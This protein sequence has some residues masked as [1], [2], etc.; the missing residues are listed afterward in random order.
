[1]GIIL[2]LLHSG[3]R[4]VFLTLQSPTVMDLEQ[5]LQ[6]CP[7]LPSYQPDKKNLGLHLTI[8]SNQVPLNGEL[9]DR[10]KPP[11]ECYCKKPSSTLVLQLH[12]ATCELTDS[13]STLD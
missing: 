13:F 1:M 3:F 9:D 2:V 8:K 6:V 11:M 7:T 4:V 5:Y 12:V 10:E